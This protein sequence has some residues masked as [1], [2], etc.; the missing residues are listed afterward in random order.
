MKSSPD[1]C[2]D[3]RDDLS[4]EGVATN[5]KLLLKLIQDHQEAS[6]RGHDERKSQ[7]IAGMMTILDDVKTRIQNSRSSGKELRRCFTDL[8]RNPP[9]DKKEPMDEKEK[10][11]KELNTSFAAQKRLGVMCASLGKEK[12]IIARELT[13]KVQELSEM[14]ELVGALKTQNERLS[15]K[16]QACAKEH[17]KKRNGGGNGIADDQVQQANAAL[18]E[19][20]SVLSEQ[21]LNSL[22]S[23]KSLKRKLKE[24]QEDNAGL[25]EKMEEIRQ[26]VQTG[27]NLIKGFKQRS[28]AAHSDER[29][30]DVR[31][32]IA[33]LERVFESLEMQVSAR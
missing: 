30:V 11:R 2:S 5:V 26:E 17:S 31:E 10:L 4:L 16:V 23:Y 32:E 6:H 27:I 20:N 22:E 14:E 13:L 18:Q 7:R 12:Q 19:R 1:L 29:P 24:V 3:N 8:K 21:L 25:R 9:R 15:A 33:R 28:A